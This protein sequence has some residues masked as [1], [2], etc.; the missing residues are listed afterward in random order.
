MN[1]FFLFALLLISAIGFSQN[2]GS[3][4][5][6]VLD[7]EMMNEPMLFAN[8][9]LKNIDKET[10]TNLHGK[11]EFNNLQPGAY[12]VVV[13]YAGYENAEI[14]VAVEADKIAQINLGLS[15]KEIDFDTVLGMDSASKESTTASNSERLPRE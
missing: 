11:F 4:R 12:T 1:K 14:P 15:A 2:Q 8:V 3:I 13:S 7:N 9:Q 10:E 6:N 5:G